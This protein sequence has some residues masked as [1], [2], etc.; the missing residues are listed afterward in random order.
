LA[1][2]PAHTGVPSSRGFL[3]Y[4]CAVARTRHGLLEEAL[5]KSELRNEVTLGDRSGLR[6]SLKRAGKRNAT[7]GTACLCGVALVLYGG[8]ADHPELERHVAVHGARI[9]FAQ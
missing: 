3:V 8:K 1:N 4:S 2:D 6:G 9:G 7:L 5:S